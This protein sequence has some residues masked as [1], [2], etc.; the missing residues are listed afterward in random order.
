MIAIGASKDYRF[1]DVR[2]VLGQSIERF[3]SVDI[4]I[5]LPGYGGNP[6]LRNYLD[7]RV[8]RSRRPSSRLLAR[9][10][11]RTRSSTIAPPGFIVWDNISPEY[12][13]P[14]YYNTNEDS[15]F[16]LGV[17]ERMTKRWPDV[18]DPR[19]Y[20]SCL[21]ASRQTRCLSRTVAPRPRATTSAPA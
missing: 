12:V 5:G 15:E 1:M 17:V 18:E 2:G 19:L 6:E 8:V 9:M 14:G 3:D 13:D 21:S 11:S 10:E 7:A 4:V 16:F 20:R